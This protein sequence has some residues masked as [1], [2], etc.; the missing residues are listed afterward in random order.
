VLYEMFTNTR[1]FRRPTVGEVRSAVLHEDPADPLSLNPAL[2]AVAGAIVR[3]CLEKNKEER[4]QS[5]RD[6]AFDLRQLLDHTDTRPAPR[7][8]PPRPSRR[9]ILVA[10][11]GAAVA[12]AL[13]WALLPAPVG[14][15]FE[16][17][18]FRRA[19][20]GAARFVSDGRAVVYSEAHRNSDLVLWRHDL[21]EN[22]QSRPLDYPPDSDILSSRS[23]EIALL[24]NRRFII[25]ERFVGT[26]ATA[27]LGGGSPHEQVEKVE[28]ADWDMSGDQLALVRSSGG[29][30]GPSWLEYPAGTK[31]YES[32][33]S[34]RFPRVSRDRRFVAFV[35]DQVGSG[36]GGVVV[37]LNLGSGAATKLTDDFKSTRGLGWSPDG[38][39]L[40]FAAGTSR[41]TRTIH[42]VTLKGRD[43]IVLSAP[44]SLTLWD[45]ARDG[46]LLITRDDD[47]RSLVAVRAGDTVERDL[48]W[49]DDSGL[50][51]ISDDGLH[52]LFS[53]RFG[54]Y[55]GNLD[56]M[57]PT[58]LGLNDAYGD[59]LSPDGKWILATRRTQA[60]LV[61][62]PTA[63]GAQQEVP[64]H[65]IVRYSGARWFPGKRRILFTG[66]QAGQA[67]RSYVQDL[68]GT[69]TPMS[70]T[71]EGI[72]GISISPDGGR[73][74]A[75]GDDEPG[76][77]IWPAT[78]GTPVPVPGSAPGDR[79]VTWS[80][81]GRSLWIFRRGEVP[82]TAFRLDIT[83][84][85]RLSTRPLMPS[86]IAG[87]YSIT[88]FAITPD[89][90]AYAYSFRR[91]LSQLYLVKGVK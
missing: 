17:L 76:I 12:S 3:R 30:G 58:R 82:A 74:A 29:M 60:G 18:T 28:D 39:E 14:P 77:S 16:Q 88:E 70:I 25:G 45:V 49:F 56:G 38:N 65:F 11:G 26:L 63:A 35:E 22:P 87:V 41:S 54:V 37:L 24:V 61:V 79:P 73:I 1:A 66:Q 21:D 86:D 62:L 23:G 67:L 36:E 71:P 85:R 44:G 43:R 27:P 32:S 90:Q 8:R 83:T 19:R 84:G 59:D 31:R 51:D 9:W 89:G 33:G 78:G 64:H 7:P 5:A 4:F 80:A 42:G 50:A 15:S 48:S 53:D 2:P 75:I 81:D 46:R 91:Q 20:L 57:M 72:W 68:D 34:I 40:W 10:A 69:T 6:L 47:R 55:L 13:W 52:L